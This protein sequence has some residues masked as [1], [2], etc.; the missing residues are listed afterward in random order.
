MEGQIKSTHAMHKSI[1][2]LSG[3]KETLMPLGGKCFFETLWLNYILYLNN[4]DGTV[5]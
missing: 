3:G 5:S 4:V 2:S 1:E